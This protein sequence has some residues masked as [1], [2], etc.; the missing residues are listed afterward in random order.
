MLT[1]MQTYTQRCNSGL[2][3]RVE[4]V[5]MKVTCHHIDLPTVWRSA[6]KHTPTH[7]QQYV[8][9]RSLHT[10]LQRGTF[11]H[12]Q[13]AKR[14]THK[15]KLD[16]QLLQEGNEQHEKCMKKGVDARRHAH[17]HTPTEPERRRQSVHTRS[18][19]SWMCRSQQLNASLDV[20]VS[21]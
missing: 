12:E 19:W 3:G 7:K 4:R 20:K 13:G 2:T 8:C 21:N 18:S 17:T 5:S 6:R 11:A 14:K 10:N 1:L 9:R 15:S 16:A